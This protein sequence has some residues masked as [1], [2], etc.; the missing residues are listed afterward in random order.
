[1]FKH[2]K[3]TLAKQTSS[4]EKVVNDQPKVE[5]NLKEAV[6]GLKDKIEK[7]PELNVSASIEYIS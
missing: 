4:I 7:L 6:E 1:M 2:I 5:L 3:E